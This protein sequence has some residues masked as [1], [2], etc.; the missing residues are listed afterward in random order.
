VEE[1]EYGHLDNVFALKVY[2]GITIN[3]LMLRLINAIVLLMLYLME[4]NVFADQDSNN[5]IMAKIILA[6]S[7]REFLYKDFVIDVISNRFLNILM[8]C[9]NVSKDTFL[10]IKD[11]VKKVVL[12]LEMEMELVMLETI[13]T[14][15][16]KNV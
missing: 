6:V 11:F 12:I 13:S 15:M 3:V 4:L 9:V 1:V 16:R 14:I 5:N 7:A 8:D 2:F 10:I